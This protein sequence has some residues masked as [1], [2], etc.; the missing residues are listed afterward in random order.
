MNS[1]SNQPDFLPAILD[2]DDRSWDEI[3]DLLYSVFSQDF[4]SER[5]IHFGLK[6]IF[7]ERILDDGSGKEEGFWHVVSKTHHQSGDRLI[8]YRRAERLPWAKP[9]MESGSHPDLLIFDYDHGAK[10][11]G[12]RRYVWLK[13][14][15]YVL[16]LKSKN[17][18][19][20][21]V[22]AFYAKSRRG[23]QD[24]QRRYERRVL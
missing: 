22:T 24:L 9:M 16:V 13:D 20:F 6:V 12:I 7:D 23:K 15:N 14:F 17:R 2:L 3:L 11:K 8:D 1:L 5:P 19:F 10:D 21:W 18:V 4:K